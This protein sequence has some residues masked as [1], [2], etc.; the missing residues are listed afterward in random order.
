LSAS[1]QGRIP[2]GIE[3]SPAIIEMFE[4]YGRNY[5]W[6]AVLTVMLTMF[7]T[8]LTSTIINV[9][10]PEIMGSFGVTQEEAQWLSTGFLA[11]GTITMLLSSWAVTA[12][13]MRIVFS[14]AMSIFLITTVVSGTAPSIEILILARTVQGAAAGIIMP[15][16]MLINYQVFPAENRGMAMGIFGVGAM[17]APALGPTIGGYLIDAYNWRYVFF[18]GVPFSLVTIPLSMMFMPKRDL[19]E[20]VP[21]F[22]WIGSL[23]MMIF[24]V[25]ILSGLSDAMEHGWESDYI[26][27]CL[28]CAFF[29]GVIFI[30]WELQVND[31]MLD[32]S[33]FTNLRFLAAALVTFVVGAGLYASTY[34][35]PLFLQILQGVPALDSGLMMLPAGLAMAMMFP[36]AGYIS[37]KT[38]PRN[39][40]IVG[41]IFFGFSC[42]VL[43]DINIDTP[44]VELIYWFIIGRI[45]LALIFPC[46]NVAS[47]GSL[48]LSQLSQGSGAV[49][50]L[51]QLG[52]A[53]GVNAVAIFVSSRTSLYSDQLAVT[54]SYTAQTLEMIADLK[55]LVAS[56]GLPA[57]YEQATTGGFLSQIIYNQASTL[58]YRDGFM[59]V[60][61]LF[62]L[63]V[64]P[65]WFMTVQRD[66]GET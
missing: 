21:R 41:L 11:S 1:D 31:P 18:V 66:A 58:A 25:A 54:Q 15:I 38:Q 16:A 34:L 45:G 33:L 46:L 28:A 9:A 27:T 24:L 6:F 59:A 51:R 20:T 65:S 36:L 8:L 52:S 50:F 12:L 53:F 55:E 42:F 37:D 60:G 32:L 40:I 23:L 5:R 39:L 49:N 2:E 48:P 19:L 3:A 44:F 30:W 10:I 7:C 14:W 26:V 35:L 57:L 17:F 62:F 56:Y 29:T 63:T 43:R 22:D 47:L 64:I 13:G 4:I 61:V